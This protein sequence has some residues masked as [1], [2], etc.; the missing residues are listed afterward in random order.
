[1]LVQINTYDTHHESTPTIEPINLSSGR[2][3]AHRGKDFAAGT[4]KDMNS[5]NKDM[6]AASKG[7]KRHQLPDMAYLKF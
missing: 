1:M 2:N 5:E 7:K 6:V 4:S 3:V